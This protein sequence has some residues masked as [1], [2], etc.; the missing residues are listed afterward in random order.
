ML[1][2]IETSHKLVLLCHANI[3]Q[4]CQFLVFVLAFQFHLIAILFIRE[5][6][7]TNYQL[8]GITKVSNGCLT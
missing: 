3:N 4:V 8:P 7:S 6:H 5:I 2:K 1:I